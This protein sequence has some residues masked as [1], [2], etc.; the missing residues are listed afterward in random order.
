MKASVKDVL[1]DHG[2]QLRFRRLLDTAVVST[3][4]DIDQGA[5]L[6]NINS[7]GF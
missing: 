3:L 2:R 7:I 1:V 5:V 4:N 6:L